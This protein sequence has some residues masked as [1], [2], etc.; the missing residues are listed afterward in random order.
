M[1]ERGRF[2]A[3]RSVQLLAQAGL[4]RWMAREQLPRPGEAI[5][6]GV[7]SRHEQ[8]EQVV[9][10]L[11]GDFLSAGPFSALQQRQHVVAIVC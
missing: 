6:D 1:L 11:V 2:P 5:R 7:V 10:Q 3:E 8:R 9:P 4:R